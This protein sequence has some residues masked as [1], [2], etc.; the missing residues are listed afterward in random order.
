MNPALFK[1]RTICNKEYQIEAV[2]SSQA[3]TIWT[4]TKNKD[5]LFKSCSLVKSSKDVDRYWELKTITEDDRTKE[6]EKELNN[7][8]AKFR[9]SD[10]F[11][12]HRRYNSFKMN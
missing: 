2:T 11:K 3:I 12:Q 6:Q 10:M 5:E 8:I 9:E 1:I 7:L 4:E